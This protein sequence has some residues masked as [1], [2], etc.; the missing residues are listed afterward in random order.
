MVTERDVLKHKLRRALS[1]VRA[2]KTRKVPEDE[3]NIFETE[4]ARN[5]G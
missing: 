1:R 3:K 5:K 2:E 4:I